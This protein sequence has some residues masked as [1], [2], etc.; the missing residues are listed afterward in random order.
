VAYLSSGRFFFLLFP[1]VFVHCFFNFTQVVHDALGYFFKV[2]NR[3]AN[4]SV[5]CVCCVLCQFERFR[6]SLLLVP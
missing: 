1:A 5:G 6:V 3:R 4:P 2:K